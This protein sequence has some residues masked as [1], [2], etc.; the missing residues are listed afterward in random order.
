MPNQFHVE[1]SLE[2]VDDTGHAFDIILDRLFDGIYGARD[3]PFSQYELHN[4]VTELHQHSKSTVNEALARLQG[5]GMVERTRE[6]W[7]IKEHPATIVLQM[8]KVRR[9]LVRA[10]RNVLARPGPSVVGMDIPLELMRKELADMEKCIQNDEP[11][12]RLIL[13]HGRFI[14]HLAALAGCS[15]YSETLKSL[16]ERILCC[17]I[18]Y[19]KDIPKLVRECRSVLSMVEDKKYC[20][21]YEIMDQQM[22]QLERSTRLLVGWL[23]RIRQPKYEGCV[24][25][26]LIDICWPMT[27]R[28]LKERYT[29]RGMLYPYG[30]DS[31]DQEKLVAHLKDEV[32][33]LERIDDAFNA[34][35]L[36]ETFLRILGIRKGD[37]AELLYL[38]DLNCTM[39]ERDIF[40]HMYKGH[41]FESIAAEFANSEIYSSIRQSSSKDISQTR[42]IKDSGVRSSAYRGRTRV[43]VYLEEFTKKFGYQRPIN[44][45]VRTQTENELLNF[46]GWVPQDS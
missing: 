4:T 15:F 46:F 28:L 22:Q 1:A 35:L 21:A 8:S 36:S 20:E 31:E 45:S 10:S 13:K 29:D 5:L 33:Y 12:R 37:P 6:G 2:V 16:G 44:I 27:W 14:E 34:S 9:L 18:V 25:H 42:P 19:P 43:A 41:S 26:K 39:V 23:E 38:I 30:V 7:K 32:N 24:R 17:R 3:R 11:T 40:Y